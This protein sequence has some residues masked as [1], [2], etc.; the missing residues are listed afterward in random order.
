MLDEIHSEMQ[1]Y[2]ELERIQSPPVLI[3]VEDKETFLEGQY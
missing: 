1:E 2:A 3:D